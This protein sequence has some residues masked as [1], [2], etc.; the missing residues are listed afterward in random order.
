MFSKITDHSTDTLKVF[1]SGRKLFF[2]G[3]KT[4]TKVGFEPRHPESDS[5]TSMEVFTAIRALSCVSENRFCL[6]NNLYFAVG[7]I[8]I[9]QKSRSA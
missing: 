8:E 1:Q 6:N 2:M 7:A 5:V 4:S 9:T 3:A